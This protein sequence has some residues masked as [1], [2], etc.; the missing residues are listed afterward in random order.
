[1]ENLRFIKINIC[2]K[3][4]LKSYINK[5]DPILK[6]KFHTK[7]KICRNLLSTLLKK[8]KQAYYDKNFEI[9][10][11]IIKNTWK[12][13]KSVISLKTLAFRVPTVLS[14]NNGDTIIKPYDIANT[15]NNYVAFVAE[16]TKKKSKIIHINIFQ[17]IFQIKAAV[18]YF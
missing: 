2:K 10:R 15:F 14:V 5:K 7:Y 18:Q 8:S 3:K 9:N 16:T 12:G 13:I 11:N 17:T 4:L 6:E 1:M